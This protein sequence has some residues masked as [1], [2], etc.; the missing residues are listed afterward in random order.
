MTTIPN[1]I[2]FTRLATLPIIIYFFRTG[3]YT[4]AASLFLIAMLTDCI[5]GWLARK[6][7][8][9]SMLGL[10]L[11]PVVD[12]ILILSMFYE[13]AAQNILPMLIPHLF[14]TR[15]LLQNAIRSCSA[16][17]GAVIGANWMGKVKAS[18][19]TI[20]ITCGMIMPVTGKISVHADPALLQTVYT[21][22]A[23]LILGITWCFFCMFAVRNRAALKKR[24]FSDRITG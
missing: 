5:D 2:T 12:K 4:T 24:G 10:Y 13:L 11:D 3:H 8:Q 23:W 15:E 9:R 18:L 6:L 19:Q 7:N 21:L 20:L 14:L 22:C 17:K 16:I 1:L